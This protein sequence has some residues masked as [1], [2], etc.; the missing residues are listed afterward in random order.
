[1]CVQVG[2]PGN[3]LT[4][5]YL[6]A[7]DGSFVDDPVPSAAAD[8]RHYQDQ[9]HHTNDDP[10]PRY[11]SGG[12]AAVGCFGNTDAGTAATVA[13]LCDAHG[14]AQRGEE[15]EINAFYIGYILRKVVKQPCQ[16]LCFTCRADS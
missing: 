8:K 3:D 10:E 9:D 7:N 16:F 4:I 11:R 13:I 12:G 14:T 5:E 15:Q 2:I 1:M 6:L